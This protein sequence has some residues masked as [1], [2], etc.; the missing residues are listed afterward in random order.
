VKYIKKLTGIKTS[1]LVEMSQDRE[2][3]RELVTTTK[4]HRYHY[5]YDNKLSATYCSYVCIK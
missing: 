3:R 2:A 4:L 5:S 1:E